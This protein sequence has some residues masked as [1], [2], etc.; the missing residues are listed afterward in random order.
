MNSEFYDALE[1][2]DPDTRLREQTQDLIQHLRHASQNSTFVQEQL[3][4]V[5][6]DDI[7]SIQDLKHIPV[8][9]KS[10]L[11]EIQSSKPVFGGLNASVEHPVTNVF[12]SPGPIYEFLTTR[13]DF[14]RI[15]RAMHASGFRSGMLVHNSFSYHFTPA[16]A[17]FENG[18]R[19][20]G[21]R[22]FPAGVGQTDMQ[23]DVISRLKPQ[24][25]A[26]TP[27]FLKIL[28]ERA[29]ES[30]KNI[31]SINCGLVSG[32]ALPP[33]LRQVFLDQQINI[34]QCYA[35]ADVGLIAYESNAREGLI[36]DE[37]IV[38]EIVRPG[39]GDPVLEGEVGEVVVT[40]MNPDYPLVRFGT[41]D[42]SAFKEGQ[43]SCGRTNRRIKGWMGRADQTTK[44]RGMFVHPSQVAQVVSRVEEV[45]KARMVVTSA[46]H[47]DVLHIHCEVESTG[48]DLKN[49]IVDCVREVCKVRATV[50]I[51]SPGSLPNDGIVIKDDRTYK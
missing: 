27:S 40:P 44:V 43:S 35:T 29:G 18:S 8:V 49:A 34:L 16:G 41:G 36:I 23:I 33:S 12:A 26:G 10:E 21:C 3:S 42:L 11:A 45:I 14:W 22:V 30:E 38:V 39:T 25:Y 50:V 32:E 37:G 46:E 15:A 48:E 4:V 2:R 17:M 31:S 19:A 51:E 13:S 20:I 5:D 7:K 47:Q 24:A 9:R 28:L 1:T 6:V